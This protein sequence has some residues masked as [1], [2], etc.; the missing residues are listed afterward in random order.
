MAKSNAYLISILLI[1]ALLSFPSDGLTI[2]G[3]TITQV[4]IDD[5]LYCRFNGTPNPVSNATVYLTCGGSTT[6][7]REVVTDTKGAFRIVLNVLETALF[8]SSIC[9]LGANILEGYCALVA[10]E[11]ILYAPLMLAKIVRNNTITTAYYTA[12]LF[13]G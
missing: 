11:N 13:V 8:S 12:N 5:V 3:Y 1:M 7:L 4:I 6:S 9:G 10:P 2:A